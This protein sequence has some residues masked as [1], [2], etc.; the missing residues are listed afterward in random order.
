[1]TLAEGQTQRSLEQKW[2]PHKYAQRVV[3]KGAKAIQWGKYSISVGVAGVTGCPKARGRKEEGRE[4][5][6]KKKKKGRREGG[7]R[8]EHTST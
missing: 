3:C 1:M 7:G 5:E 6:K 8:G 2:D 4:R